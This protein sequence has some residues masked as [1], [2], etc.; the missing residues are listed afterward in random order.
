MAINNILAEMNKVV[1]SPHQV[2]LDYKKE[3]G[4][5]VIGIFPVY[6]PEEIVHA[7]GMLPIG[8]WGGQTQVS[9]AYTIFP[10]FACSIM[11][12]IMEFALKGVYNDLDAVII[13]APCDTLK[14]IGQ[15]WIYTMPQI[16]SILTVYPQMRK[17]EAGVQYLK[18][19]FA[20]VKNEI[21]T[22]AGAPISDEAIQNS[23]EVYNEHR[24][25]MREFTAVARM[26]PVTISAK[27][28]HLV[29]KSAFFMEKGRHTALVKELM[30]ELRKSPAEEWKGKKVIL[31]GIMAEPD[32]LLDLLTENE[33][34]VVGDDL[35]QESRQFRTDV[36]AGQDPLLRLAQQ[37]SLVE[38]CSLAYDPQKKRGDMIIDVVKETGAD[39]V[40]LCMMKFCDPEEFDYP[41]MTVQFEDAK[42]PM[43]Y[44]EIDQ[45]LQSAE[46]ARTRIQGFAEILSI[47]K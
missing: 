27:V 45:Q 12:S 10:S 36:P 40:I 34:A 43:L 23:I 6:C 30:A 20:R 11:Q 21:E 41:I 7:A 13:S 25:T 8:M 26:Y 4:K 31:T 46:Q 33:L 35:A 16:M 42:V 38:G 18:T 44:L 28:R 1:S 14:S 19:E 17:L 9:R 29:I 15:D 3:T 2:V 24:K 5:G 37:W 47:R 22:I 32:S 39:G